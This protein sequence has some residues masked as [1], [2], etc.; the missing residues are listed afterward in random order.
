M[1]PPPG[2]ATLGGPH[3]YHQ[4]YHHFFPKK[5]SLEGGVNWL[6]GMRDPRQFAL[7]EQTV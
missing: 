1:P 2:L 3:P 5:L 4:N 6:W 7:A